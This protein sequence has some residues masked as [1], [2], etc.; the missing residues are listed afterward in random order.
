MVNGRGSA[1]EGCAD[2]AV[3]GYGDTASRPTEY[4]GRRA[5][6]TVPGQPARSRGTFAEVPGQLARY[7]GKRLQQQ[8]GRL[9]CAGGRWTS[10]ETPAT[11][12]TKAAPAGR[13]GQ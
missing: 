3:P 11:P 6:A 1:V 9:G 5:F 2:M 8:R 13:T 10:H 4:A 7:R 12:L